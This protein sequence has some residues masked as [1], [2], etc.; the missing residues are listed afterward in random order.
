MAR[1]I[2][3]AIRLVAVAIA[4]GSFGGSASAQLPPLDPV[5]CNVQCV[6]LMADSS[7]RLGIAGGSALVAKRGDLEPLPGGA[8]V[9][10]GGNLAIPTGNV[11]GEDIVL[12][13]AY[14]ELRYSNPRAGA[15]ND[16]F[17]IVRGQ[18][19]LP[20]PLA[21]VL[22][23]AD[24]EIVH[25][26]MA[27][28][29]LD[30]GRNLIP[31]ASPWCSPDLDCECQQFCLEVPVPRSDAHYFFFDVDARY[32]FRIGAAVLDSPGAAA[33][34]ILDPTDPF[35]YLSGSVMGIPGIKTPLNA[36]SGGFGFSA[37][38][39]IPYVPVSTFGFDGR[40]QEFSGDAA[41]NL[42][43][44][45]YE[46]TSPRVSIGL[47]GNMV[48]SLDPDHD[49]DHPLTS[50][51]A[52]GEDPDLAIG[53]NGL[54][55]VS[56]SPFE[57]SLGGRSGAGRAKKPTQKKVHSE[58]KKAK[59]Q[60]RPNPFLGLDLTLVSA[61]ASS[62]LH[63]TYNEIFLSGR[64]GV[65]DIFPSWMPFPVRGGGVSLAAYIST[66]KGESYARADGD[67]EIDPTF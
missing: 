58:S 52:F 2:L 26:P 39:Q 3:S 15:C 19:R 64:V 57:S 41:F 48:V 56:W 38:S 63:P 27:S 45:L 20:V 4:L 30:V 22:A 61:S 21:G 8:G 60:N 29:G 10:A 47:T 46:T 1:R 28:V 53:A 32:S 14:L 49:G 54:L 6:G 40:E 33:T 36:G 5:Y 43:V 16:G 18:T 37:H 9:V 42:T 7:C 23:D 25:Q 12:A 59:K 11:V 44:P 65:D 67:M 17:D 34:L 13:E 51:A 31:P 24:V 55:S 35:F 50:P 66:Q 62:R